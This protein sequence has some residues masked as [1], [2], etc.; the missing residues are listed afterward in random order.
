MNKADGIIPQRG[1]I[2]WV[3][4]PESQSVGREQNKRR[5]AVVMSMAPINDAHEIC[6]VVPLTSQE[7]SADNIY[8]RIKV[9]P[10]EM[11][12]ESGTTGSPRESIAL[13]EQI[14]CVSIERL[15]SRR[16]ATLKPSAMGRIEAGIKYIL[17]LA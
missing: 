3:N 9:S 1:D 15:D 8:H 5:P 12:P 13:T 4:L 16:V 2:F 11:V 6:V 17:R 10:S 7:H 14:R